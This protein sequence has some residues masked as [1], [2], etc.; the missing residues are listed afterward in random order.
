MVP[1]LFYHCD[2]FKLE[3]NNIHYYDQAKTEIP[4]KE[5]TTDISEEITPAP[6]VEQNRKHRVGW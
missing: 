5:R 3:T 1:I 4:P 2:F 6:S